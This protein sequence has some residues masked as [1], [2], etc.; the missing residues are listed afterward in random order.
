MRNQ[1]NKQNEIKDINRINDTEQYGLEAASQ[2]EIKQPKLK[3]KPPLTTH[4]TKMAQT[5]IVFS[6][7]LT[8]VLHQTIHAWPGEP[9]AN[10]HKGF[11]KA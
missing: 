4:Y 2:L 6:L 3:V 9:I 1:Q 11:H 10:P 7:G 5:K 8:V